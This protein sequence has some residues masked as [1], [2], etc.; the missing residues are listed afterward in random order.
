M[1]TPQQIIETYY[2]ESRCS[3][4]E[5]AAMLDRHD[6]AAQRTGT[7]AGNSEKLTCLRTAL[8]MMADPTPSTER[9]EQ[10]LHLFATV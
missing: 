4:L 9:A 8:A 3:L 1:L 7:P 6:A 10:L 2:L 5:I